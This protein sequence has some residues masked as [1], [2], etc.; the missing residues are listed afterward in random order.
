MRMYEEL[1][2]KYR[3]EQLIGNGTYGAVFQAREIRCDRTVAIKTFHKER[4]DQG[5]RRY[6]ES[7]IRAM[8]KLWGHPNVVSIHTLEPGDEKYLAFLVMEYVDGPN[9]RSLMDRGPIATEL[10]LRITIDVCRGL[11]HAHQQNIIHRDIKP[12]NILLTQD[13]TAKL[14]DFG[15]ARV[16]ERANDSVVTVAGTRKYMAPEQYVGNYDRRVDLYATGLIL[17]EMLTRDLPFNGRNSKEIEEQKRTRDPEIPDTIHVSFRPVIQRALARDPERRYQSSQELLNSLELIRRE[18]YRD[19]VVEVMERYQGSNMLESVLG[20][21]RAKWGFSRS[22]AFIIEH[23]V[24]TE[25]DET[26]KQR[27]RAAATQKTINHY[28]R[29]RELIANERPQSA[30]AEL[31]NLV[32]LHISDEQTSRIIA[33]LF[34]RLVDEDF[35]GVPPD[36]QM[37]LTRIRALPEAE[38][39]QLLD[40]LDTV[41][42]SSRILQS[43]P[44]DMPA[45]VVPHRI[46]EIE[47]NR[48]KAKYYQRR[49]EECKRVGNARSAKRLLRKTGRIY[50]KMAEAYSKDRMLEQVP[51]CYMLAA[52]AYGE[53]ANSGARLSQ[54]KSRQCYTRSARTHTSLAND[55]YYNQEWLEAGE[56]YRK[57]ARAY[58]LADRGSAYEEANRQAILAYFQAAQEIYRRG[59]LTQQD[60]ELARDTCQT[61]VSIAYHIRGQ[62]APADQARRLLA[63]IEELIRQNRHER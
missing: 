46:A 23:E 44:T 32:L 55:Y 59:A 24:A 8:G 49:A 6:L 15:V 13:L 29:V 19:Y 20:T 11:C 62:F 17:Y 39:V 38:R 43:V 37:L 51:T 4:Y 1:C 61:A 48:R 45:P 41:S 36:P 31:Q 9:L 21:R 34:V 14:S 26:R 56:H 28:S 18:L 16:L 52:R 7:E 53:A 47:E 12:Q 30:L 22:D 27:Q 50:W 35:G 2:G 10:I 33:D 60:L 63:A 54:R 57:A 3:I 40:Q 42:R 5:T 58:D 25:L